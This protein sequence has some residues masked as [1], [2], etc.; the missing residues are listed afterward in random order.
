MTENENI[1]VVVSG[2]WWLY[3]FV[4]KSQKEFGRI[5][6]YHAAVNPNKKIFLRV[7]QLVEIKNRKKDNKFVIISI[8]YCYKSGRDRLSAILMKQSDLDDLTSSSLCNLIPLAQEFDMNDQDIEKKLQSYINTDG[9]EVRTSSSRKRKQT[10]YFESTIQPQTFSTQPRGKPEKATTKPKAYPKSSHP[11]AKARRPRKD[12]LKVDSTPSPQATNKPRFSY[13]DAREDLGDVDDKQESDYSL[14]EYSDTDPFIL[15]PFQTPRFNTNRE[16][17]QETR[18]NN[19][20]SNENK[21]N[22]RY[23]FKINQHNG[24]FN[25]SNNTNNKQITKNNEKLE[26]TPPPP[27]NPNILGTRNPKS[28]KRSSQPQGMS[29]FLL[30]GCF[31]NSFVR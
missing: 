5:N 8:G 23:D 16:N 26:R 1:D 18:N 20:K 27:F 4:E 14:D 12:T 21:T 2:P 17:N 7:N 15:P 31:V 24:G 11:P 3:E 9:S 30:F 19:N 25:M 22:H 29:D 6:K 10:T 28:S 13:H